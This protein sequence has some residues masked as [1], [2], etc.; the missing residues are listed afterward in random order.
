MATTIH[1]NESIVYASDQSRTVEEDGFQVI[2]QIDSQWKGAFN[3]RV[4]I[5]NTSDKKIENWVIRFKTSNCITNLWNGIITENKGNSYTIKNAG[6]NANIPV[7]GKVEFGFSATGDEV[8]FPD[9]YSMPIANRDIS[10]TVYSTEYILDTDWGS[11]FGARFLVTNHDSKQIENWKIEFDFNREITEIWNAKIV[12][13]SGNHYIIKNVEYNQNIAQ[14]ETIHIG[15][16]GKDGAV[17]DQP[18]NIKIKGTYIGDSNQDENDPE[19]ETNPGE[20]VQ[21]EDGEIEADYLYQAIYPALLLQ[22]KSTDHIKLSDDY[23]RDGLTLAEE[24]ELDLNP[25]A[26]DTDEDGV[27]DTDEIMKYKTNP[28]VADTDGDG[29]KDGTEINAGL[30]PNKRDSDGDGIADSK[31]KI[32]QVVENQ[33]FREISIETSKVK[34]SVTIT[35]KGDFSE[36]I[37]VQEDMFNEIYKSIPGCIGSVFDFSM[38]PGVKFDK[39]VLTFSLKKSVLIQNSIE[40]LSIAYYNEEDNSIEFLDTVYDKKNKKLSAKVSHFSS[41]LV[42]NKDTYY[43]KL[44]T[45]QNPQDS[46]YFLY[47]TEKFKNLVCSIFS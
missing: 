18:T 11:G 43:Q 14:E 47:K 4:T 3:A 34:P 36:K 30:N 24:Y 10:N 38:V 35:G 25:F 7:G 44:V 6:W 33:S 20:I 17:T 37:V 9:K 19:N 13:H 46:N 40:N 42:I 39:C 8:D 2:Y 28:L 26:E 12:S 29:M 21:L 23:D 41:Y 1:V 5:K 31:E 27:N 16:N 22:G 32:V 15:F 45:I